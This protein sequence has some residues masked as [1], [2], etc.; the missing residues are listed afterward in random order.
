MNTDNLQPL[1]IQFSE[2]LKIIQSHRSAALRV[3]N[4]EQMQMAWEIGA[5]VSSKL[6][7]EQWGSKVVTQLVEYVQTNAPDIRGFSKKNIYNMVMF[8]E[9]YSSAAFDKVLGQYLNQHILHSTKA[10]PQTSDSQTNRIVQIASTQ[11]KTDG[12]TH[13]PLVAQLQIGPFPDLLGQ[14]SFSK[15]IYILNQ[16]KSPEERL[17]Y[18]LYTSREQLSYKDLQR[19]ISTDTFS[20]LLGSKGNLSK[21]L[22]ESVPHASVIFK[23][24]A[25][26]DFLGLPNKYSEKRLRKGIVAHIKEFILELGKDFIFMGEEYP[27]EVGGE[28][29]HIDLLFFHR[30]IQALCAFELKTNPF[31]PKDIGQLNFYLEALDRDVKRSNEN[32]SVGILLCPSANKTVVEYALSR[33]MSPTLVAEYKRQLIPKEKMQSLLKE[34]C[35]FINQV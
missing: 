7:T 5:Y 34:Y 26:L 33:N 1:E 22:L 28:T 10:K 27:L 20:T 2:L 15:H 31:H 14:I 11:F 32:P 24:T 17:F 21:G 35:E 23:D 30:G 4:T 13:S 9:E 3:V 12:Q 29:F 18:L 25:Y 8:Y 19:C 6:K 16:C